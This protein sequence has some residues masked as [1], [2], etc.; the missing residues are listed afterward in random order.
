MTITIYSILHQFIFLYNAFHFTSCVAEHTGEDFADAGNS[1]QKKETPESCS[2]LWA[3]AV[4]WCTLIP[5]HSSAVSSQYIVLGD[6]SKEIKMVAACKLLPLLCHLASKFVHV[7]SLHT[8]YN[9]T[10]CPER[11]NHHSLGM[12]GNL[13]FSIG[14]HRTIVTSFQCEHILVYYPCT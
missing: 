2:N 13:K 7:L 8:I 9:A 12:A 5:E 3:K 10:D 6:K 1:S 14:H 11:W 4:G